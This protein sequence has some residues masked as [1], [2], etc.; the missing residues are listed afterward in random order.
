MLTHGQ[1]SFGAPRGPSVVSFE[2]FAAFALPAPGRQL[3]AMKSDPEQVSKRAID[4]EESPLDASEGGYPASQNLLEMTSIFVNTLEQTELTD[5]A[6]GKKKF[7]LRISMAHSIC[8]S[9]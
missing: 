1:A 2:R 7:A 6:Q 4:Q 9:I 5:D 8:T 3:H